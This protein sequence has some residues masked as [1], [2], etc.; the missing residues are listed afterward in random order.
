M[1]KPWGD[2]YNTLDYHDI[3]ICGSSRAWVQYSPAILDSALNVNSY[4]LGIDGSYINRQIVKY[5]TYCRH[6]PHPKVIIQNIDFSTLGITNG[7]EREQYFPYFWTDNQLLNDMNVFEHFSLKERYVPCYRYL[8]YPK[9]IRYGLG[10]TNDISAKLTKG[11][12]GQE[13]KWNPIEFNQ[14]KTIEYDKNPLALKLFDKYLSQLQSDSVET[15]FVYAPIYRGVT[16]K[17]QNIQ[18]MYAMYDSFAVKYNIPILDYNYWSICSDT[19]YFYNAMHLNK[20]GAE[21]FTR[22][23]AHDLD[24]L[25]I[26]KRKSGNAQSVSSNQYKYHYYKFQ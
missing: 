15:I 24:S 14:Q 12:L 11:Y 16:D 7:Y 18:G 17:I 25:G 6:H 9:L 13:Q 23:L 10:L 20:Q 5:T 3:T 22:R 26:I 19:S 21:L 8:G 1:F 4:N 2:I